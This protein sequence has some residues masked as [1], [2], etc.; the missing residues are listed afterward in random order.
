MLKL[1]A[2]TFT[3]L[4]EANCW[5]GGA[6][7]IPSCPCAGSKACGSSTMDIYFPLGFED[8]HLDTQ[9]QR[10]RRTGCV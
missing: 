4:D 10:R 1:P 7:T 5:G 3:S 6:V 9:Q 8:G 2:A